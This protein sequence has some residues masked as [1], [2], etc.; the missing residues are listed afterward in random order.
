LLTPA[1]VLAAAA[2]GFG[3]PGLRA[4]DR[5]TA[6]AGD[7]FLG[8]LS[9][10]GKTLYFVSDESATTQIFAQELARGVPTLLFDEIADVSWPRP[11]P[12]GKWIL[13]ISYQ[14]DAAGDICL[15]PLPAGERR[16]LTDETSAELQAVWLPDGGIGAV[17]RSRLHGD[18]ELRR[19]GLDGR[20]GEPLVSGSLSSPT[21]SPDG[22]WV[23]YV[24]VLRGSRDVG[25]TFLSRAGGGLAIAALG[26]GAAG[27]GAVDLPGTSG[28]PAFSADGKHL[29]F[30]QFLNDTNLDGTIDGNDNGVLFRAPFRDG[31]LGAPEQ[32]TSARWSCQYPVPAPDRLIATCLQAGSLDVFS[33]P[34]EGGVPP[35]WTRAR[36]DDELGASRDRWEKLLL[37]ARRGAE[38]PATLV[39]MIRL[40]L[41]LGEYESAGFYATRLAERDA[42]LGGVLGEIA[43]HHRAERALSRGMLTSAFVAD[44]RARL[45]RLQAIRHPLAALAR[46]EILDVL[47]NEDAARAALGGVDASDPLVA[48]F[49][50]ERLLALYR[51]QPRYFMLY[52]PIAE[53]DLEHAQA[54]VR[55]LTHGL[56]PAKRVELAEAELRL[57]DPGSDLAFLL[58]LERALAVLTPENQEAVREQVFQLY[59]KNKEFARRKALVAATV[60]RAR[61]ADSEFLF[62]NFAN[63]WGGYV[64]RESAERP[65]AERLYREAVLERAYVAAARGDV[66]DARAQFFGVTLQT[67][68]LDAHAG[69]IE[70]RLLEKLDPAKDYADKPDSP[71]KRYA[72]AYLIARGLP[73]ETDP[74]AHEKRAAEAIALLSG[75][76]EHAPQRPEV[77]QLWG[78]V[79][80]QRWL[81]GGPRLA[82]VEAN[83]HYLLALDLARDLPR[84]RAAILSALGR[85]QSSVGNHAI[86]L[87]WLEER[88][89]L[90]FAG[91]L[92]SFAHCVAHARARFHTGDPAAAASADGCVEAARGELA[93]FLPLAIDR[94]A[95]YHLAAGEVELAEKRYAEL[96]PMVDKG[97]GAEGARNRLLCRTGWATALL[98]LG[99]PQAALEHLAAAETLLAAAPLVPMEG[100]YGRYLPPSG[101]PP[102]D[103]RLHLAGLRAQAH[104]AAGQLAEA[105]AAMTRRRDGIAARLARTDVDEDR[106]DLAH[107][108]AQLA[109][110]AH[111]ARQPDRALAHVEAALRVWD[112]WSESTGTPV[113]DT[114]LALL[115]AYAELHLFDR[116]PLERLKLDLPTRV[117]TVYRSLS[118]T[119]NPAW[120]PMR[121]RLA[122]YLTMLTLES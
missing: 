90:P 21:I 109:L 11:S 73:G 87:G 122:L 30:A 42:P 16:C 5:L 28:F 3:Q 86:A 81:R 107:A 51:G 45:A 70:M 61:A 10:D 47:G 102:G 39:E 119:R 97:A 59:R 66:K 96:W 15:R 64:P 101:V 112:Q 49:Y 38:D 22:K 1:V 8:A 110:Y 76:A 83:A 4:P 19:L 60:G 27:S 78:F 31:K 62:Y 32:L 79:A 63:T 9:P 121:A 18:F 20:R 54:F 50:A 106:L 118:E 68:S 52:R 57:V 55:E 65:R 36:I 99:K 17:T 44:A 41:E 105:T 23:A 24:P 113:E 85:L 56:A 69:F 48:W 115:A 111:R 6:G 43:A 108:E 91:E 7:Q 84:H 120:E 88:A 74:A 80:H 114:G 12:D 2:A 100:P 67:E 25:P 104:F 72:T 94:S 13:Y 53:R 103:H 75:I 37:L 89:K 116:L 82:A 77:H 58:E 33:L 95:L 98:G 26:G 117:K 71:A 29:Y 92:S 35:D 34:L 40:H 46:S 14:T 93:R